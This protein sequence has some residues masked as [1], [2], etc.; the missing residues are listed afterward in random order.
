MPR[1]RKLKPG[2]VTS[3]HIRRLS[4]AARYLDQN[5]WCWLD[6]NGAIEEDISLIKARV[7]PGDD[8]IHQGHVTALVQEL[9]SGGRL[10]RLEVDGKRWLVRKDFRKEQRIYS[11]EE[12]KCQ[13]D[14]K[15]LDDIDKGNTLPQE[16]GDLFGGK[17]QF[18]IPTLGVDLPSS[19]SFSST[20][21]S[22]SPSTSNSKPALVDNS[23]PQP[24]TRQSFFERFKKTLGM[25]DQ[26]ANAL[27]DAQIKAD[28]R[29]LA[30]GVMG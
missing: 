28:E 26:D 23:A 2:Y 19:S 9:V 13:I 24:L 7:F 25:S 8:F 15:V 16:T 12:R 4:I 11:D 10:F 27:A 20:S 6:G 21:T 5:L 18:L 14:P 3:S 22:S 1:Q 17:P 29:R 30:G